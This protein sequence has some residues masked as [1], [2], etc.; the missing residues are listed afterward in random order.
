M[1]LFLFFCTKEDTPLSLSES[2]SERVSLPSLFVL[3]VLVRVIS[4]I[5]Y[6][7]Q[8]IVNKV[9]RVY[10]SHGAFFLLCPNHTFFY[11]Y[12]FAARLTNDNTM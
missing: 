3:S 7:G 10:V 4:A 8:R 9:D 5:Q 2:E 11:A 12:A 1:R 6:G